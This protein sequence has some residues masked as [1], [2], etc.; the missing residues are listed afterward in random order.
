MGERSSDTDQE[1]KTNKQH[2]S[3]YS[4]DFGTTPQSSGQSSPVSPPSPT[5]PKGKSPKRQVPGN[6]VLYQGKYSLKEPGE[7]RRLM[8]SA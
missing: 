8:Q 4:S 5:N 7:H 1:R 3:C 2:F 6:K